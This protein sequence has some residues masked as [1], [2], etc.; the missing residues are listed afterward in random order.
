MRSHITKLLMGIAVLLAITFSMRFLYEEESWTIYSKIPV[1]KIIKFE[2]HRPN[3]EP[4]VFNKIDDKWVFESAEIY[5]EILPKNF[6]IDH[7]KINKSIQNLVAM[8]IG[9]IVTT[10]ADKQKDYHV[11]NK[12]GTRIRLT[13]SDGKVC[14]DIIIGKKKRRA[15]ASYLREYDSNIIYLAKDIY[16]TD[17]DQNIGFWQDLE[18]KYERF[19][20]E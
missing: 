5:K 13:C 4:Y 12:N 9:K 10:K 17:F 7:A 20:N 16:R 14:L 15:K 3:V 1:S 11:D 6:K 18:D 19:L 2:I 8:F